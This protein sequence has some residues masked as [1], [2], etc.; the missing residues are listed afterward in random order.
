[1]ADFFRNLI[2]IADGLYVIVIIIIN[3]TI[4]DKQKNSKWA[5]I[6]TNVCCWNMWQENANRCSN[7][8]V[9]FF[10]AKWVI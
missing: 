10:Y 2:V 5:S 8:H 9:F 7:N 6:E 1:M 3:I 4:R